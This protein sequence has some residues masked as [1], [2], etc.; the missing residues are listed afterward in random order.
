MRNTAL[1]FASDS[2]L[3]SA[4]VSP[5]AEYP[6]VLPA[7][8][9]FALGSIPRMTPMRTEVNA[10]STAARPPAAI[11][12]ATVTTLTSCARLVSS[13]HLAKNAPLS[14]TDHGRKNL[15]HP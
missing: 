4:K 10:A 5:V 6:I 11:L 8:A 3:A 9:L 7:T 12:G 14:D 13:C 2:T 15:W 1:L